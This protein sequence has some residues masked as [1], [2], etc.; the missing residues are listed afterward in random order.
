MFLR[1]VVSFLFLAVSAN[2]EEKEFRG[3]KKGELVII[4][5]RNSIADIRRKMGICN[6][7][8]CRI[9]EVTPSHLKIKSYYKAVWRGESAD[10]LPPLE[11]EVSVYPVERECIDEIIG[12][13]NGFPRAPKP[14]PFD[15]W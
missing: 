6:Y 5:Y 9:L 14:G 3:F 1:L 7:V 10:N 12:W 15:L 4:Q 8:A 13:P 11:K 2:A